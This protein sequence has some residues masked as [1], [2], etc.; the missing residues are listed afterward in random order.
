MNPISDIIKERP[1]YSVSKDSTVLAAVQYMAQNNVGAVPVLHEGRL[2]G[3]FS[4][5]DVVKR[6]IAR[7]LD[8]ATTP[9]SEVMTTQ[10]VV[11]NETESYESCL[12]KMQQAHCRHLPVVAGEKLVGVVSLRDMLMMDL[13]AKERNIEYLQSY[14]YTVPPGAAKRYESD[15]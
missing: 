1:L 11:A 4:E 12:K 8:T 7:G 14:I 2:V 9:I 13:D 5:R 6:V 10:I 15:K 3:I